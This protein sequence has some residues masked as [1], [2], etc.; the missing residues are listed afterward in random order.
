MTTRRLWRVAVCAGCVIA[1]PSGFAAVRYVA[2]AAAGLNDGSSWTNAFTDLRSALL[3]SIAGDEVRVAQGVYRP[4]PP[5][6]DRAGTFLVPAGVAMTGGYAGPANADPDKRE[7]AEFPTVLSGDLSADD[8]PDFSGMGENTLHVVTIPDGSGVAL[9]GFTIRAGSADADGFAGSRGAGVFLAQGDPV[10]MRCR[11]ERNSAAAA[12]GIHCTDA[13]LRLVECDFV[14]NRAFGSAAALH[15]IDFSWV[16][17]PNELVIERC[18]FVDN[19]A[20]SAAAFS[21]AGGAALVVRDSRFLG[22][23]AAVD[24]ACFFNAGAN[25]L[26]MEF[27]NCLFDANTAGS[28]GVCLW[29]EVSAGLR[30]VNCTFTRNVAGGVDEQSSVILSFG[31]ALDVANSIIWANDA[32]PVWPPLGAPPAVSIRSSCVQGGFPGEGNVASDPLFLSAEKGDFRL[33]PGSP[34]IDSGDDT[35]VPAGVLLDLAGAARF[36]DDPA[37]PGGS[38]VDMGVFERQPTAA[39]FNGDGLVNAADLAVLLGA[40]GVCPPP[41]PGDLDGDGVVGSADLASLLGQWG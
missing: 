41:C 26:H 1:A 28:H 34:C 37:V 19:R 18:D 36:I 4:A 14:S 8:Q 22:N 21:V 40:W 33:A 9:D 15:W 25:R 23:H 10:F 39:D 7:P 20:N 30:V 35:A 12:A 11:F 27:V 24:A 29:D 5:A 13:S 32:F 3:V 17:D 6:G 2:V 38:V 31:K 16:I